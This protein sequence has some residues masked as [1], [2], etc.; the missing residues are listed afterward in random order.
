MY[1]KTG[2][3]NKF[4]KIVYFIQNLTVAHFSCGVN[5]PIL[6]EL[7]WLLRL[8]SYSYFIVIILDLS[9]L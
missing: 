7:E 3:K 4:Y 8:Y 9:T 5:F 1:L 6:T 2:Q